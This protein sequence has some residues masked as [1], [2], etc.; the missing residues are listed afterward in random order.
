MLANV[1]IYYGN[2]YL[3]YSVSKFIRRKT[4]RLFYLFNSFIDILFDLGDLRSQRTT[5]YPFKNKGAPTKS[6]LQRRTNWEISLFLP[7]FK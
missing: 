6:F 3:H 7:K 2:P 1:T 5:K 4:I